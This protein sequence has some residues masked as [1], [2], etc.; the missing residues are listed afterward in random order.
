MFFKS[1]KSGSVSFRAISWWIMTSVLMGMFVILV[2]LLSNLLRSSRRHWLGEINR[3]TSS[4]KSGVL[5]LDL[6][7]SLQISGTESLRKSSPEHKQPLGV[8]LAFWWQHELSWLYTFF[9]LCALRKPATYDMEL[10][11]LCLWSAKLYPDNF[12]W[13]TDKV[14]FVCW[15]FMIWSHFL[16]FKNGWVTTFHWIA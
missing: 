9:V 16:L 15:I 3:T 6:K 5:W 12:H 13:K 1:T 10:R 7:L 4:A 8:T 11:L 2:T 14:E